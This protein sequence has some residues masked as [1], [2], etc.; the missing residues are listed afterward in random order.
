ML[1]SNLNTVDG[2]AMGCHPL[3]KRLLKGS[4]NFRP[5]T[6]KYSSTWDPDTVLRFMEGRDDSK[7]LAHKLATL[8][9][10]ATLCRVRELAAIDRTSIDFS[11]CGVK[12]QLS[13]PR[14]SLFVGAPVSFS[15]LSN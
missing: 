1:S 5:P 7:F 6:L 15:L 10:L 9:T 12:F 8:L 2:F 3:V 11:P 4:Y 14:K 13:K